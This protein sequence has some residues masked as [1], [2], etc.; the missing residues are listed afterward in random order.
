MWQ[1]MMARLKILHQCQG[2]QWL[3]YGRGALHVSVP[4]ASAA[5]VRFLPSGDLLPHSDL[6]T[7]LTW[8]CHLLR[9]LQLWWCVSIP[10]DCA[11]QI[12][13]ILERHNSNRRNSRSVPALILFSRLPPTCWCRM[14]AL[15]AYQSHLGAQEYT[16]TAIT[17]AAEPAKSLPHILY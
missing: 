15:V 11:V 4:L 5:Q 3:M 16:P 8:A 7:V 9:G 12:E 6:A 17:G 10:D 1:H 2:R 13:V 14:R